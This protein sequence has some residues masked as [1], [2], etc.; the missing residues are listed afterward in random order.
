MDTR[1]D[2]RQVEVQRFRELAIQVGML[3]LAVVIAMAWLIRVPDGWRIQPLCWLSIFWYIIVFAVRQLYRLGGRVSL[4]TF[5]VL[6]TGTMLLIGFPF[7]GIRDARLRSKYLA[8]DKAREP[9]PWTGLFGWQRLPSREV[10]PNCLSWRLP[11]AGLTPLE[12]VSIHRADAMQLPQHLW[13][14]VQVIDL[15]IDRLPTTNITVEK[16]REY[17]E[18]CRNAKVLSVRG[19]EP[20]PDKLRLDYARKLAQQSFSFD[21]LNEVTSRRG[22]M[23]LELLNNV[24][25][26]ADRLEH[27]T[28]P[29]SLN[30]IDLS[31]VVSHSLV[32]VILPPKTDSV[33]GL[34]Q[35]LEH[36]P[37]LQS[38]SFPNH[39]LTAKN[40]LGLTKLHDLRTVTIFGRGLND[41]FE[42]QVDVLPNV[43]F[44]LYSIDL[45]SPT[46]PTIQFCE[47]T[48]A[49]SFKPNVVTLISQPNIDAQTL[50]RLARAKPSRQFMIYN[51]RISFNEFRQWIKNIGKSDVLNRLDSIEQQYQQEIAASQGDIFN[52]NSKLAGIQLML[53]QT[54]NASLAEYRQREEVQSSLISQ[55]ND[56]IVEPPVMNERSKKKL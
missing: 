7:Q 17:I 30:Q 53:E 9:R 37:E 40:Q 6:T 46:E 27:I 24:L 54:V 49:N 39:E 43:A 10:I 52:F 15:N 26:S 25:S 23:P 1:S 12:Q 55:L 41:H 38:L 48:V 44:Q 33:T 51:T 13:D 45:R 50:E 35:L 22:N 47:R 8:Y 29:H 18:R 5:V 31:K 14:E 2:T 3:I 20:K 34:E 11:K 28:F 4:S 42:W 56:I 19:L 16:A 32:S 21:Q 36:S